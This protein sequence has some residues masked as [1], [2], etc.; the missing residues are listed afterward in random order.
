MEISNK[1]DTTKYRA[2]RIAVFV[3]ILLVLLCIFD[4]LSYF[5][6]TADYF[7]KIT[8]LSGEQFGYLETIAPMD[9][10]MEEDGKTVLV[11]GD[12]VAGQM[13]ES[14]IG[15]DGKYQI[16]PTN[17]AV[18]FIGQYVYIKLFLE[19]HPEATDVYI[20][21]YSGTLASDIDSNL[22]YQYVAMPLIYNG[23]EDDIDEFAMNKLKRSY[24]SFFLRKDV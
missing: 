16:R 19:H 6:P 18:T 3:L 17:R 15:H 20:M 14:H 5:K 21:M 23:F 10:L 24:G 7:N 22:A 4:Y 11:L 2:V 8:H 1:A 9:E 13:L 12:S